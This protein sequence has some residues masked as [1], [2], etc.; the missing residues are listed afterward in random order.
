MSYGFKYTRK[1]YGPIASGIGNK[2]TKELFNYIS[3][4]TR[5]ENI[6]IFSKPRVLALYTG[7]S[8]SVYHCTSDDRGLRNYFDKIGADYVIVGRVFDRD[9][10]YLKPFIERHK[11]SFEEVY[12]NQDFTVY[13]IR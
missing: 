1:D 6:F 10:K 13:R 3:K 2:E 5:L 7:R 12:S 4:E 9:M 8:A 11:Q